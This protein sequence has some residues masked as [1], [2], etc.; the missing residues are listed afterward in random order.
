MKPGKTFKF[1]KT[2]HPKISVVV[3]ISGRTFEIR[4][5][6]NSQK[7]GS[8]ENFGGSRNFWSNVRISG[9]TFGIRKNVQ[10]QKNR[11]SENFGGTWNFR[12]NVQNPEKTLKFKK[13]GHPKNSATP[14]KSYVNYIKSYKII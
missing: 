5:N 9:R 2:G 8:L 6:V 1:R 3:G 11:S 14:Q 12:S 10:I 13:T 7:N 4:K